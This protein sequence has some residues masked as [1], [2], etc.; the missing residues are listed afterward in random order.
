MCWNVSHQSVLADFFFLLNAVL[1]FSLSFPLPLA[2]AF[3]WVAEGYI[4]AHV[5][6]E[7][8]YISSPA[9]EHFPLYW[10]A[11]EG[12][13][14]RGRKCDYTSI[15]SLVCPFL[16]LCC[17]PLQLQRHGAFG[18]ESLNKILSLSSLSSKYQHNKSEFFIT[19]NSRFIQKC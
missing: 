18:S 7:C 9:Q 15:K 2:N 1:Y 4:E 5:E 19:S 8:F 16:M 11:W 14:R 3:V 12:V 10:S 13:Q 6:A 17:H